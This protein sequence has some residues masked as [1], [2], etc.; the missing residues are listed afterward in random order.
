M[1]TETVLVHTRYYEDT[2]TEVAVPTGLS[3]KEVTQAA[4]SAIAAG[5]GQVVTQFRKQ[6]AGSV[7]VYRGR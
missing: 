7:N 1:K 4:I 6:R 2:Y 3:Q 5:K